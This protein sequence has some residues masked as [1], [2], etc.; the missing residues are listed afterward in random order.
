MH[1]SRDFINEHRSTIE[2]LYYKRAVENGEFAFTFS[3]PFKNGNSSVFEHSQQTPGFTP[4]NLVHFS[5]CN[6][7]HAWTCDQSLHAWKCT[8]W[9]KNK[10][11]PCS[12]TLVISLRPQYVRN[13]L[14]KP[15]DEADQSA[16]MTMIMIMIMGDLTCDQKLVKTSLIYRTEPKNQICSEVTVNSQESI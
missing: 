2:E 3:V 15:E 14:R 6:R 16:L 8:A 4:S 7:P 10:C 9:A 11:D 5:Y 1:V 12:L 13:I